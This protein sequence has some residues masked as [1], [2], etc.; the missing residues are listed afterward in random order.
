M[1]A[2]GVPFPS[3]TFYFKHHP[4]L[5]CIQDS[6]HH[7][8]LL[9]NAP[10]SLTVFLIYCFAWSMCTM[11]KSTNG[12][13]WW[14]IFHHSIPNGKEDYHWRYNVVNNFRLDF[15]NFQQKFSLNDKHFYMYILWQDLKSYN[16]VWVNCQT[17]LIDHCSCIFVPLACGMQF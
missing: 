16:Y 6:F 14:R 12:Y 10:H 11:C 15:S 9:S 7:R 17:V 2:V 5:I 1:V 13:K 4:N 8:C 3:S